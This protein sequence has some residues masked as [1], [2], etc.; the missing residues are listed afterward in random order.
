MKKLCVLLLTVLTVTLG[1]L[2]QSATDVSGIVLSA[3][4]NEPVVGATVMVRGTNVGTMT[5]VDGKFRLKAPAGSKTLIVSYV[6]MHT[7]EVA[8]APTVRVLLENDA[9]AL[10]EVIVTGYGTTRRAALP[11]PPR[12]STV[13]LSTV[14]LT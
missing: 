2:A 1:A 14:S 8:V 12:L 11:E 6:G 4:E 10:D 3:E 9:Q 13:T 7:Q 5:D